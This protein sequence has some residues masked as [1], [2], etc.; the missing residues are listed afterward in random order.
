MI[1]TIHFAKEKVFGYLAKD[2]FP[3]HDGLYGELAAPHGHLDTGKST[4]LT[5]WPM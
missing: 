2:A 5:L 4:L 1:I 3:S